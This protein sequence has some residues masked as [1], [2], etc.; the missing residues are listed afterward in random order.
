MD[1]LKPCPFYCE[2]KQNRTPAKPRISKSEY[3]L[4]IARAVAQRSTCLRRQYGAVIVKND[5]IIAT[6]YNGSAR[7]EENCCDVGVCWREAHGIPHGE[8]YEKC[9]AVHAEDNAI[10]QAGR[11]A[12]G[13]TLYLAGFENG[14]PITAIP[15]EMC[16]R[17][18]INAQIAEVI[19]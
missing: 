2:N 13:A 5:R 19:S 4:G 3:Y 10:N 7:G 12:V 6:G 14:K 1:E 17:K 8:R 16:K 15:C 11:E 9:V 18:I